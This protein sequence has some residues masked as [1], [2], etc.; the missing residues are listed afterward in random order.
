MLL[1]YALSGLCWLGIFLSYSWYNYGKLLP[2]YFAGGR[3]GSDSYWTALAGNL[4]SPSRGV[5]V[6]SPFI[7]VVIM[8]VIIY[9]RTLVAPALTVHAALAIILHLLVISSFPHWW[10]GHSYG[11]RLM[12][13]VIPWIALLA[14]FG[15]DALRN[16]WA[17]QRWK[18]LELMARVGRVFIVLIASSAILFS[19]FTHTRGAFVQETH[20]WNLVINVDEYPVRLWDWRQPQF[21]HYFKGW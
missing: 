15:I 8:L 9:S 18:T 19:L 1:P 16:A 6:Y 2:T 21:L 13:D 4:I 7:V 17:A 12:T 10:G 20:N 3:L 14:I 5:L 11:P